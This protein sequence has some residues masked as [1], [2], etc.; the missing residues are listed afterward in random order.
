MIGLQENFDQ[1]TPHSIDNYTYNNSGKKDSVTDQ[2]EMQVQLIRQQRIFQKL[3]YIR[4]NRFDLQTSHKISRLK[5][6]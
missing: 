6:V 2:E 4:D 3:R 1:S 5:A